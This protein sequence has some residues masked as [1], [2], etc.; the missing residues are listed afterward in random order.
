MTLEEKYP[1]IA[2]WVVDGQIQIGQSDSWHSYEHSLPFSIPVVLFG[3][4]KR[5][6]RHSI[7]SLTKWKKPLVI[8]AKNMVSN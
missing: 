6:S 5:C 3:K 4:H 7:H 2:N 1:F 8:G